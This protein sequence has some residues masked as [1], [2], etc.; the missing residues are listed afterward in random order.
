MPLETR[1]VIGRERELSSL[2]RFLDALAEGPAG[3]L[4]EGELGIGKT[5]LCPPRSS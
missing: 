4:I 1:A 5:T 3:L 2:E